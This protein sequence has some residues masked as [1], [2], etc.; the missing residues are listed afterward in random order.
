[1]HKTKHSYLKIRFFKCIVKGLSGAHC[2][3]QSPSKEAMVPFWRIL[4]SVGTL[5]YGMPM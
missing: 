4:N 2:R 1:M 3:G 5:S